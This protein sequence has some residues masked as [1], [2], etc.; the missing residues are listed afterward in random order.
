MPD[1]LAHLLF[2]FDDVE[3][4]GR[5]LCASEVCIKLLYLSNCL[6]NVY[7]VIGD[8]GFVHAFVFAPET[9]DVV[10]GVLG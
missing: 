10:D 9:D 8:A 7:I 6:L 2:D 4:R 5:N 3:E 1:M